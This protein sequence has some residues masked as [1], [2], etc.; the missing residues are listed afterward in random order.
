MHVSNHRRKRHAIVL[1][2]VRYSRKGGC[3][4]KTLYPSPGRRAHCSVVHHLS[5]L[6][7]RNPTVSPRR[8]TL[9]HQ[10]YPAFNRVFALAWDSHRMQL[11]ISNK[12]SSFGLQQTCLGSN[13]FCGNHMLTFMLPHSP[14]HC[15]PND[16]DNDDD[17]ANRYH[18]AS[19]LA[20]EI[21]IRGL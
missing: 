17:D 6:P 15:H 1:V 3:H 19:A 18:W 13:I 11:S 7:L 4:L 9:C 14:P 12:L 10:P 16:D 2:A 8:Q 5:R 21:W 20:G